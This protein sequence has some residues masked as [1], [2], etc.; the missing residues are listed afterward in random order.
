MS[1]GKPR[2]NIKL[3]QIENNPYYKG[4]CYIPIKNGQHPGEMGQEHDLLSQV[5]GPVNG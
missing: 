5:L 2:L 1:E 3:V 4:R